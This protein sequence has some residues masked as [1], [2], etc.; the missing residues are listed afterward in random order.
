MYPETFFPACS[1]MRLVAICVDSSV[2][3]EHRRE[4]VH[5]LVPFCKAHGM[6][7]GLGFPHFAD[8]EVEAMGLQPVQAPVTE[9]HRLGG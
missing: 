5:L 7:C 4:M 6:G 2:V 9:K 1:P 3:S 8:E